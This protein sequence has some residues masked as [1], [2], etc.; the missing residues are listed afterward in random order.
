MRDPS[1]L[2]LSVLFGSI[3]CCSAQ[4]HIFNH[5]EVPPG[6]TL[7]PVDVFYVNANDNNT[8]SE[9]IVT[10]ESVE[11]DSA[12]HIAKNAAVEVV[13]YH[14]DDFRKD[15]KRDRFCCAEANEAIGCEGPGRLQKKPGSAF[16]SLTLRPRFLDN[17][18]VFY[19]I[20][21]KS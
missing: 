21:P 14:V 5:F 16:V 20:I 9:A 17:M 11:F 3:C 1:I 10:F 13:L 7:T 18:L 2:I 12:K 15:V 19:N 4:T 8:C 6:K